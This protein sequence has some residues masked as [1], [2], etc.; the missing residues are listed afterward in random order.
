MAEHFVLYLDGAGDELDRLS[1]GPDARTIAAMEAALLTGFTITEGKV[2]VITGALLASG[3]PQSHHDAFTWSGEMDFDRDPGIFELARGDAP[4]SEH[5]APGGHYFFGPP[6]TGGGPV[7]LRGVRQ[8][9]W[10]WVTDYK[11]G[12]APSGGLGPES[13]GD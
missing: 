5:P 9:F 8:A 10:N 1:R 3:H 2:H 11:G 13:G 4:T 12:V 6:G 7:F